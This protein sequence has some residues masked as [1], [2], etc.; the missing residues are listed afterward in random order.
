MTSKLCHLPVLEKSEMVDRDVLLRRA[1]D[2]LLRCLTY[3]IREEFDF[4]SLCNCGRNGT[5]ATSNRVGPLQSIIN[6]Q[7]SEARNMSLSASTVADLSLE[8][9]RSAKFQLLFG[10]AEKVLEERLLNVLKDNCSLIHESLLRNTW[11]GFLAFVIILFSRV[12]L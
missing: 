7:I 5:R 1:I 6:D 12:C 2:K 4:S 9:L 10:S 11:F 3:G 8:E